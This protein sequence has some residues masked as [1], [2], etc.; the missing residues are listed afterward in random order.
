MLVVWRVVGRAEMG[1]GRMVR[2]GAVAQWG[3]GGPDQDVD[4]GMEQ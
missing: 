2:K 1:P 3:C 4:M